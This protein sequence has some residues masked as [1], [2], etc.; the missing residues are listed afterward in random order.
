MSRALLLTVFLSHAAA[1]ADCLAPERL[2]S[3][4]R[5]S[6]TYGAAAR[7]SDQ[8]SGI[9]EK[10]GGVT[11]SVVRLE[12]AYFFKRWLGVSFDG[13]ADW[14]GISGTPLGSPTT[15]HTELVG[16]RLLPELVVRWSPKPST[17]NLEGHLGWSGGG[18]PS[19]LPSGGTVVSAPLFYT[20]PT[21]AVVLAFEPNAFIGGQF[22]AR[23][24]FD[25]A[26]ENR[27]APLTA[28]RAALVWGTVGGQLFF[29]NFVV[30]ELHAA[31]ALDAELDAALAGSADYSL[32]HFQAR[33]GLGLRFRQEP[34]PV[35]LGCHDQ[36]EDS[37][38][39]K[40]RVVADG[41]GVAHADIEA[42]GK[43]AQTDPAGEFELHGISGSVHVKASA[44]G[45]KP[46]EQDVEVP[47]NGEATVT[48]T[49]LKPTGPGTIRGVVKSDAKAD[50]PDAPLE[51]AEVVA[52]GL[53]PVKTADDGSFS[54][55]KA[56]PGPVKVTVKAKG[57]A[58]GEEIVQVPAE[59]EAS[60][61]FTLAKQGDKTP[62]TI[63]GLIVRAGNGKPVKATVRITELNLNVQVKPDGRFVVQVPGGK[64]TL[65]IEAPG[66]IAQTKPV[67]VADG[68]QAIFHCDLQ[69]VGR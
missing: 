69:P 18:W 33:F 55:P 29:G 20:G 9:E 6:L 24:S 25:Y 38:T 27:P 3:S 21:L 68:D 10:Y 15:V 66:F 7:S 56:G 11:P 45:F 14:F 12:G 53:P 43:L 16:F 60:V 40:G 47:V 39:L 57:F 48:L 64:Y 1:W 4:S 62:A 50:K 41:A 58:S 32:S 59:A 30:G 26:A 23:G 17:F 28:S 19:Y 46:V 67:E 37:G 13:S 54:I 2:P 51:G 61:T 35:Q 63:R 5:L 8:Q 22:Y 65:V 52:E 42:Q 31:I 44:A 34:A 49:L 36:I